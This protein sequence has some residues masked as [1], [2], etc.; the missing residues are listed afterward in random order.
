MAEVVA[1]RAKPRLAGVL[2]AVVR[3][4]VTPL[5]LTREQ[6]LALGDRDGRLAVDVLRHLHAARMIAVAP[7]EPREAFPLTE[8]TFQAVARKLGVTVG[9]KRSRGLIR[10]LCAEG[11]VEPSGSYRQR[12]TRG[13]SGFRVRL[14]RL[15][16]DVRSLRAAAPS[17]K[18]AVGNGGRVNRVRW[19]KHGLF[20]M[21][22]GRPPPHLPRWRAK[23]MRSLDEIELGIR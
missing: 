17:R 12:Y 11:V 2:A 3:G 16:A 7:A 15:T 19:W 14:Y 8:L 4:R 10:R 21:P 9:I 18:R 6:R 13:L 22:D 1:V 5:K 20:G 23:R